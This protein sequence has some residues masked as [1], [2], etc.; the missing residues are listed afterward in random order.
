MDL[1]SILRRSLQV[2]QAIQVCLTGSAVVFRSK[3]QLLLL[4][5]LLRATIVGLH[6]R[7]QPCRAVQGSLVTKLISHDLNHITVDGSVLAE[8]DGSNKVVVSGDES[9]LEV[10]GPLVIPD[11]PGVQLER[12]EEA[13]TA[14]VA[15][16]GRRLDDID[17]LAT[18]EVFCET[19]SKVEIK[20]VKLRWRK[21]NFER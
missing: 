20:S 10:E 9:L 15:E 14:T 4:L 2:A 11:E 1:I 8:A 12:H 19:T 13:E 21:L 3:C 16:H 7:L 17:L 18:L 5:E 6:E